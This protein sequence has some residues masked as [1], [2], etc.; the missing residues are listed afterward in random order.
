[1]LDLPVRGYAPWV[2]KPADAKYGRA[3]SYCTAGVF[4]LGRV[5]SRA[6]KTPVDQ[7]AEKHLFAPLGITKVE[8]Q[9]SPLGEEQTGGGLGLRSRDLATLGQL[10]LNGGKWNG[11]QVVPA[12]WVAEST[13]PHAQINDEDDYGYLIW[14]RR[15]KADD[16]RS[17]A[18]YFT[19][20]GGNRV[21][22]FPKLDA[23]VVI[24]SANFNREGHPL[25]DKLI[26]EQILPVLMK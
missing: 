18:F 8:W 14:L 17:D 2:K 15:F 11:K 1:M 3:Y 22:V 4:L 6:A 12:M 26:R 20:A 21:L 7:F 10:Y 13:R 16:P 5:L 9:R 24:T 19:G 23:V 25:T